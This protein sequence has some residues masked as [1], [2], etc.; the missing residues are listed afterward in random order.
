M[1]PIEEHTLAIL[2]NHQA[3]LDMLKEEQVSIRSKFDTYQEVF[4]ITVGTFTEV[5]NGLVAA[6]MIKDE[7]MRIDI[8][9]ELTAKMNPLSRALN[10]AART[11]EEVR[12]DIEQAVDEAVAANFTTIGEAVESIKAKIAAKRAMRNKS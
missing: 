4:G 2:K 6:L 5:I 11:V 9:R 3:M 10:V 1:P 7:Q 8:A 12:D